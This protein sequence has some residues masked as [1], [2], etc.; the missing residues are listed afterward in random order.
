[1]RSIIT[2]VI[3][4]LFSACAILRDLKRGRQVHA[5]AV[6]CGFGSE[7]S[8]A[9]SLIVMYSKCSDLYSSRTIFDE[10]TQKSL[11]SW[12]AMILGCKQNGHPRE[13][14]NL[15]VEARLEENF[16]LDPTMLIGALT[17]S[18]GLAA[19]EL[20]QQLHCFAF[21]AGF[22]SCRLVENSLI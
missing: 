10:T 8:L 13:A 16:C 9:N 11:V 18:S 14:L 4:N 3:V 15:L 1:M 19:F 6:V 5:Y 12:T 17:A 21:E 2:L 20:C 7:L 22:S